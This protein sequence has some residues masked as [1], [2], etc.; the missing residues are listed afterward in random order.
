MVVRRCS[1]EIVFFLLVRLL[2]PVQYQRTNQ[3][4]LQVFHTPLVPT[5]K[6]SSTSGTVVLIAHL[7]MVYG[8]NSGFIEKNKL[9]RELLTRKTEKNQE[10]FLFLEPSFCG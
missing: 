5:V 10:H 2:F 6:Y 8:M 7:N 3:G 4:G 9:Y 1:I